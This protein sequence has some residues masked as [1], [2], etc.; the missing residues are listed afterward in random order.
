MNIYYYRNKDILLFTILTMCNKG[1][2]D[3]ALEATVSFMDK[4]G[5][6]GWFRPPKFRIDHDYD[7]CKEDLD[8]NS[9]WHPT[10]NSFADIHNL[11][12]DIKDIPIP[13]RMS[14]FSLQEY[15]PTDRIGIT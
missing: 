15:S 12:K 6:D 7:L 3:G 5:K 4:I 2:F 11:L 10:N 1:S 8:L 13:E 9:N 14:E